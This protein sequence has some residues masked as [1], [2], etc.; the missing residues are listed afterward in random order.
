MKIRP[1]LA[2]IIF[3]SI[4]LP[5]FGN[6]TPVEMN[7]HSLFFP[8]DKKLITHHEELEKLGLFGTDFLAQEYKDELLAN[9]WEGLE[10]NNY[11]LIFYST[12]KPIHNRLSLIRSKDLILKGYIRISKGKEKCSTYQSLSH[13]VIKYGQGLPSALKGICGQLA[14]IHSLKKL[15]IMKA[16][17]SGKYIKE[18][19]LKEVTPKSQKSDSGMTTKEIATAHKKYT[20]K[21]CMNYHH[22]CS[23]DTRKI[24]QGQQEKIEKLAKKGLKVFVA[25]LYTQMNSTKRKYDCSLGMTSYD[26]KGNKQLSHIEHITRVAINPRTK[27]AMINTRNG[28]VQG[29]MKKTVPA[30]AGINTISIDPEN[31]ECY[32]EKSS[33]SGINRIYSD[34]SVDRVEA[35]CC[36]L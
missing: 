2:L 19:K 26:S 13:S 5:S 27:K 3:I 8:I 33:H 25:N 18:E 23:L 22:V 35:I 17:Y 30:S 11:L 21:S 29:D 31:L 12:I 1:F 32:F 15:G 4:T 16:P 14:T 20:G 10:S 36:P 6:D 34:L 24:P 28:F 7:I 9:F